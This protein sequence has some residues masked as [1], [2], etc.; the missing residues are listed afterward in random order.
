MD[1]SSWRSEFP[2]VETCTYL[3]SHSLGAMPARTRTYL[4][5]FADE[6]NARG[7]RAWHE[8]WW[9]TGREI[10]GLLAP[11]LGVPPGTLTLHQN[12]TVAQSIVLSCFSFEG[13]RRKVV[14]QDLHFRTKTGQGSPRYQ[15]SQRPSE[16]SANSTCGV[17]SRPR[18][19]STARGSS[20]GPT[21]KRA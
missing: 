17:V 13:R 6:W 9:E 19:D 2:I 18:P 5:R 21:T 8:G 15:R 4:N 20:S 12:A 1:L 3:V 10:G 14:M 11:I 16:C 7:V